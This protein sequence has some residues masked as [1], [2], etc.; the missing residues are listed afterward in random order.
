M[1]IVEDK[2]TDLDARGSEEAD[3]LTNERELDRFV[4]TGKTPIVRSPTIECHRV[5]KVDYG[6]AALLHDQ[7]LRMSLL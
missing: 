5:T 1:S 2:L 3:N 6:F 4:L 7:L